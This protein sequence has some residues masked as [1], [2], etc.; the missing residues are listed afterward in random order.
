MSRTLR[1]VL[2]IAAF[3]VF[4]FA[5]DRLLAAIMDRLVMSTQFRYAELYR[6]EM[7]GDLVILGNSRG[8]HMFHPPAI[9]DVAGIETAN[10]S[11]NALST[12]LMPALWHDYLEYQAAPKRLLFEVSCIGREDEPGALAR[13]TTFM[14][15]SERL[16]GVIE[17]HAPREYA[18]AELSHLFGFNNELTW[19]AL[20]FFRR[21]DQDWI[22]TDTVSDEQIERTLDYGTEKLL[23]SEENVAAAKQV[24]ELA[25]QHDVEVILVVAPFH[26][27]YRDSHVELPDWIDWL[28]GQ[29]GKPVH[30]Y[31]HLLTDKSGFADHM[32]LNPSGAKQ[33]AELLKA[34]GV[35]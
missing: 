31:S 1:I 32:H 22:M 19:R 26:P 21:S 12:V 24:L 13:F 18:A 10:I 3:V 11:F 33:L 34:D 35:L 2:I 9:L 7:K 5:G 4:V 6:G 20:M 16:S 27:D 14:P 23:R 25:S 15:H 8:L 28:E 29:L 30:D 17:K